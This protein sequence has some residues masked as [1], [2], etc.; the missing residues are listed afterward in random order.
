[1]ARVA[2]VVL[3]AMN[4]KVLNTHTYTYT[5]LYYMAHKTITIS[6]EAYDALA[7]MKKES[8]SFTEVILRL[9]SR[10]NTQSFLDFIKKLPPSEDLAQHIEETMIRTRKARLRKVRL[11]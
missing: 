2:K 3:D 1:M 9:A 8:E 7:R 6:E 5:I 4:G 10:G 11:N